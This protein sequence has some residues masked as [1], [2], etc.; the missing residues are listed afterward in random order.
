MH[1]DVHAPGAVQMPMF[2]LCS[3][4]TCWAQATGLFRSV[5]APHPLP[6]PCA[7]DSSAQLRQMAAN[8]KAPPRTNSVM[9]NAQD[10]VNV[11]VILR[12]RC[13]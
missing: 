12:C 6:S 1:Q 4:T 13:S 10:A 9:G 11:Q 8:N 3:L 2:G 7:L 5:A